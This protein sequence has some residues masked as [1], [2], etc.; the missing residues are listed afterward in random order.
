MNGHPTISER[1]LQR[2]LTK[3]EADGAVPPE[4]ARRLRELHE[5]GQLDDTGRILNAIREGV[6]K[7]AENPA[8]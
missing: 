8:A 5:K 1:V 7:R 2:F 3:V 4:V 6:R